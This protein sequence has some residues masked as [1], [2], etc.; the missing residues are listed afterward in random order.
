M[1][2]CKT[3]TDFDEI[4]DRTGS[5]SVKWD[6]CRQELGDDSLLPLWVA[7]MDFRTPSFVNEEIEKLM[8]FGVLG[9]T[10]ITQRWYDA[11]MGWYSR[12]HSCEV[13]KD[14]MIFIPGIVRGIAFAEQCFTVPGDRILVMS[15]VYHP[16]FLVSRDNGREVV[17]NSLVLNEETRQYDIDFEALERQMTGCRMMIISN[18]H[19]P[20]GRVWTADELRRIA[21]IADEKGCLVISDEIHCDLTHSGHVHHPYFSVSGKAASNS[22]VFGAPSKAFNM[23][24]L[25][26]SYAIVRNPE[27]FARFKSYL[28]ASEFD[29][30]NMFACN[31]CSACYEKGETWL[32]EMLEYVRGNYRFLND[33]LKTRLPMLSTLDLQATYLVFLDCRA[34]GLEQKDLVELFV[35]KAGIVLNDGTMFGPEGKGF[36]RLNIGCPRPMLREALERLEKAIRG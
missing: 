2:N 24:G 13:S 31:T 27:I 6:V 5:G 4:L 19:N 15:P 20:G 28:S 36:M 30:G 3:M 14:E 26:S 34:L 22:I 18:P 16:F 7:D 23:P 29:S 11:I 25:V 1:E 35:R 32:E 21:E 17:Y 10:G 12:R 9:Y 8:S 33:F